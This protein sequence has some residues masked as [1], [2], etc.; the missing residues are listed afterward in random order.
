MTN[1]TAPRLLAELAS[2]CGDANARE[3]GPSDCLDNVLPAAVVTPGS[4][5]ELA[6]VMRAAQRS[7]LS[8]LVRGTGTKLRWGNPPSRVD[9]V[10]DT[11][12]MATVIEHAAGDLV[13][14]AQAGVPLGVLQ[15]HVAA[16]GQRLALGPA[17]GALNGTLGGI[18][19]SNA[20]GPL[21]HRFGTVRDLLIGS[22]AVLA[23]G[24]VAR[25]GGKVVKNVAGYDLGKLFTGSF[26]T[27]GVL[28]ELTFRLHPE[29]PER[30]IVRL[31]VD[32]P[33]EAGSARARLAASQLVASSL[34]LYWDQSGGQGRMEALFEGSRASAG[35]QSALAAQ[36]WHGLGAIEIE[37]E[38]TVS[39]GAPGRSGEAPAASAP[40]SAPGSAKDVLVRVSV[41]PSELPVLL[42]ALGKLS[43]ELGLSPSLDGHAGVGSYHLRLP[44]STA[45]HELEA[46]LAGLRDALGARPSHV[47]VLQSPPS[48]PVI[49][50]RW[51]PVPGLSLMR[52]V[53]DAFDPGHR[54][55]PGRFV[56]GI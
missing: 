41:M 53:K 55:S 37:Q 12:R 26:G 54:L 45:G 52:A 5:A 40:G 35:N 47:V 25:S 6:E 38:P 3:A 23:D 22:T 2:I 8:L 48:S 11:A 28:T 33:T 24:T 56:G 27:L 44:G 14:R 32:G 51:G 10:M 17:V 49:P 4:T 46:M 43:H 39:R 36:I 42:Q 21:R 34:E 18:V 31:A 7:G 1:A 9:L 19:A 29:P 15:D 13:V 16:S 20:S 50:D 30:R